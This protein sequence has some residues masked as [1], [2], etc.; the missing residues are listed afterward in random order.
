MLRAVIGGALYLTAVGLLGVR[1]GIII[2]RTAG[3]IN[4]RR[5]A[6]DRPARR[7]FPS[8]TWNNHFAKYLPAKAGMAVFN[9]NPEPTS[10]S[11]WPGF[12]V[13][14][15]YGAVTLAVGGLLLSRNDA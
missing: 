6:D 2:R 4:F 15:L 12:V 3:A 1:L 11:P 10:L 14:L 7:Q 13:L 9:V 5:A 8:G